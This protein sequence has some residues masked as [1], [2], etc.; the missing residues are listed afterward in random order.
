MT[1]L[2]G[3]A[4]LSYFIYFVHLIFVFNLFVFLP[5]SKLA[6]YCLQNSCNDLFRVWQ[7][8]IADDY[9]CCKHRRKYQ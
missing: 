9:C 7:Q 5:Y 3:A 6:R 1:R 8:K 4:G 2:G